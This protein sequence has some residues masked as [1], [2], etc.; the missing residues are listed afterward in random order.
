M[1][2]HNEILYAKLDELS[3]DPLNPRLGRNVA[4]PKL[5]QPEVLDRMKDWALAVLVA[6]ERK[7][8]LSMDGGIQRALGSWADK[9]GRGGGG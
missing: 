7:R 2:I 1:A 8:Y 4:D 6:F 9:Q 3:L 5:Q